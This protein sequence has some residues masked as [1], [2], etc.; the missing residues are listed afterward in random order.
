MELKVM[1]VWLIIF[2]FLGVMFTAHERSDKFGEQI[3]YNHPALRPTLFFA[4]F[5]VLFIFGLYL[6]DNPIYI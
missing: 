1:I 2:S 5:M 4:L 3:G 6:N